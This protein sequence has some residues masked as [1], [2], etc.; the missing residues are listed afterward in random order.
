MSPVLCYHCNEPIPAAVRLIA[1]IGEEQR[2][3]CCMGCQAAVEWIDGL[4]LSDY[5]R[6]RTVPA[7]RASVATD[8]KIWDRVKIQRLFVRRNSER[9]AEICVLVE[10]LRCAACTWLIER[11][12][13]HLKGVDEV[14]INPTSK[15]LR[16]VWQPEKIFLSEILIALNQLGYT[17]HPLNATSL[18]DVIQREQRIALKRLVIAGIGMMQAMMY[19]VALYAGAFEGMDS[20]TRDFFRW[21]GFLVTTP[22]VLYSAQPFFTGAWRDLRSRHLGMDTPVAFAIALVYMASLYEALR[23]GSQVYFDSASMFVF[24]LLCGR[25]LEMRARHRSHDVV[26]ALARLQPALAQRRTADATLE[27]VGVHE[28]QINDVVI[29]PVGGVI[30]ADGILLSSHCHADESLLSGES[31]PRFHRQGDALIAGSTLTDGPI[32]LKV[33]RIGADTVLS[34]IVRLVTRAQAERP[35]WVRQGE[36]IAGHFVAA[37]FFLTFITCISWLYVDPSRAFPAVLAVLVVSCPCA[38]AL[39]VPTTLSR[40]LGLMARQGILVLKSDALENL[41]RVDHVVFD[42]TGT[43]SENRLEIDA[44]ETLG[45]LTAQQCLLLAA[46]LEMGNTHPIAQAIRAKI[47]ETTLPSPKNLHTIAGCGVEGEIDGT[48]LRLGKAEFAQ[49]LCSSLLKRSDDDALVLANKEGVLARFFLREQIREDAFSVVHQ[50]EQESIQLYIF[51]GDSP[52]RVAALAQHVGIRNFHARMSP[53]DKLDAL[54]KLRAQGGLVAM[55]GDGVND[56]PVLAGADVAIALG[57]GAELAQSSADIVIARDRL[58]AFIDARTIARQT[59]SLLKQNLHWAMFYNLGSIPLAAL[60]WVP[61]WLAAIGMSLSSLFVVLNSFR[62]KV[63][64]STRQKKKTFP[65]ETQSSPM[66]VSS[67][68]QS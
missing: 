58:N 39:A 49:A 11:A 6:L 61:P 9:K 14:S 4:G 29:V 16:L 31:T 67:V 47:P 55:V 53:T 45:P 59:L 57:S 21:L 66:R 42:K 7:E 24:F 28:L 46:Q 10:G 56:A 20:T 26:D 41:V 1:Q 52:K 50:L 22:V 64:I 37:V 17:P 44:I 33:T 38:F 54:R 13:S 40:A 19:A 8:Y 43:L 5:Y 27:T 60:G 65:Y 3:V 36:V 48:V 51:S 18:D 12:L 2:A 34:S 32:E 25:Y 63:P 15:R 23:G 62:I 35:R 30:P 68:P